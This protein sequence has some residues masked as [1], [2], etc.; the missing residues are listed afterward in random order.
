MVEKIEKNY[1]DYDFY[2]QKVSGLLFIGDPHIS[3]NKPGRRTEQVF[4]E[5][6]YKK[7]EESFLIAEKYDLQIVIT[8]DLFN[9]PVE[10]NETIKSRLYKLFRSSKYPVII[11]TGNHDMANE[12]ELSE[13]DSLYSFGASGVVNII[14][15]TRAVCNL[16]IDGKNILLGGTPYGSEIPKDVKSYLKKDTDKCIWLTHHDLGFDGVYPGATELFE[17]KNC[18]LVVNGHMHLTKKPITIG[19]TTW[20]NPGNITRQSIDTIDH[21]PAVWEFTPKSG[22][23]KHV[24]T[25]KKDIFNLVGK[26]VDVSIDSK[27]VDDDNLSEIDAKSL[28]V[29]LMKEESSTDISKTDDGSVLLDEINHLIKEKKT[30][31]VISNIVLNLHKNVLNEIEE[32]KK[33]G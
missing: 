9:S 7:L 15:H 27:L 23:K 16:I 30:P 1:I 24:L 31:K 6:I 13:G 4:W 10:Y 28:F 20:F 5:V 3:S 11:L 2:T 25:Y 19:D 32:K 26:L 21:V 14:T 33:E 17:M 29:D 12:K 22:I 18:N 8:G